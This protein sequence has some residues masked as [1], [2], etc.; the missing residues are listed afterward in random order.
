MTVSLTGITKMT[1][2]HELC[3]ICQ[4]PCGPPL[5]ARGAV[6][7]YHWQCAFDSVKAVRE[8]QPPK[9]AAVTYLCVDCPSRNKTV[10]C[11][12]VPAKPA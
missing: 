10:C 9:R 2:E 11:R 8:T 7:V 5:N 1:N 12:F 3:A 4:Q 6:K